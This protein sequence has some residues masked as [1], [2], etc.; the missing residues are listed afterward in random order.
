MDKATETMFEILH[1]ENMI[2]LKRLG[3]SDELIEDT[4]QAYKKAKEI[5]L[6]ENE[7]AN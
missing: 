2:I 3:M 6:K 7:D 5:A 4:K 1:W